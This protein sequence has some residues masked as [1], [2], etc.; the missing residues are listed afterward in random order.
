MNLV[1]LS[2]V[3]RKHLQGSFVG[4]P[5]LLHGSV[6]FSNQD[7]KV[8]EGLHSKQEI[9]FLPFPV[10]R[11]NKLESKVLKVLTRLITMRSKPDYVETDLL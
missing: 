4:Y 1:E 2:N 11:Y 9:F 10:V 6:I 7:E 5:D 3:F 8:I